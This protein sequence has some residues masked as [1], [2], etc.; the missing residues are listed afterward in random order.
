MTL[1][2]RFDARRNSLDLLRTSF[3]LLVA[4]SHA[5][6]MRTGEQPTWNGTTLGDVAVDG[7][8]VLSGFLVTRSFLTL[9]SV[10][11]YVWH[12]LLRIMPGFYACLLV[13]AGVLAPLAALLQG[14]P[15]TSVYT[16]D[17]TAQHYLLANAGLLIREY[18]LGGLF[19]TNPT[20]L[21]VNGA[22][23]TLF[24]E[25]LCYGLVVVCGIA[26]LLTRRRAGVLVLAVLVWGLLLLRTSGPLGQPD[27]D[28]LRLVLVFLL[29]CLA[30]LYAD[31]I[32]MRSWL[33][34]VALVGVVVGVAL[35]DPYQLLG[36]VPLAYLLLWF[37]A[38]Y[39]RPVRLRVDLSY[40]VYIYHWPL[41]QL[42]ALTPLVEAPL[43]VFVVLGLL[44][45]AGLATAS[46]F[47]VE[48]PA[49]RQKNHPLPDR[50]DQLVATVRH[51][52][53]HRR[54]RPEERPPAVRPGSRTPSS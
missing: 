27:V 6:V 9:G 17:P 37:A 21:V 5:W 44:L 26:G 25:A 3:A 34:V 35:S 51:R 40:G 11:R 43:A 30:Q 4:V 42:L 46:W 50:V 49:L 32:P 28:L 13:T 15:L 19:A 10:P 23:W 52:L 14:L 33:A 47:G 45:S 18:Q 22:L 7:F 39:P 29:G 1:D 54:L 24:F 12:R 31:R 8:F 41:L 53:G 38:C 36:G 20:P 48:H 16:T 2:E